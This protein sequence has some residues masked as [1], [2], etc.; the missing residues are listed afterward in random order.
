M[1]TSRC[2][3]HVVAQIIETEFVV[4]AVG[5]ALAIGD[6]TFADRHIALNRADRQA[7]SHVQWSHPFHI[8]TR[9]IIVNG[10]DMNTLADERIQIG[11]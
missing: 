11:G 9:Q 7:Q 5:D 4:G 1:I 10:H 8:P 6:L 2:G 3:S